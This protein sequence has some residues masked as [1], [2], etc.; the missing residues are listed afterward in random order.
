MKKLK[1][2]ILAKRENNIMNYISICRLICIFFI[3]LMAGKI[4]ARPWCSAKN[5][6]ITEKTICSSSELQDLDARL[7]QVYGRSIAFGRDH[8][9]LDWLDNHRNACLSNED[10]IANEYRDRIISLLERATFNETANARPWCSASRLNPTEE[11]ICNTSYLRDLDA[12]LQVAYG[13]ARAVKEDS[14]QL[15]WLTQKRNACNQE[16]SCIAREYQIRI[17][18]LHNKLQKHNYIESNIINETTTGKCSENSLNEL[19]AVCVMSAV[20]EQACSSALYKKLPNGAL[21]SASANAICSA[22]ASHLIDGSIDPNVLGLSAASGFLSGAGDSLL[23]SNDPFNTFFGVIFKI[24]SIGM[25]LNSVG[26]CFTNAERAC[27]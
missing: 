5:L 14:I 16:V 21:S 4:E 27:Q 12:E 22:A 15:N 9:Q 19:K 3:L 24:G 17:A 25:T 18:Q 11:T 26:Q 8:E 20:G 13:Q 1:H 10:C 2:P 23:E 7:E 6:N